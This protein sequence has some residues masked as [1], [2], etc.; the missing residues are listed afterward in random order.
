[1]VI[2]AKGYGSEQ[3]SYRHDTLDAARR[4]AYRL[5]VLHKEQ[6]VILEATELMMEPWANQLRPVQQTSCDAANGTDYGL[7]SARDTLSL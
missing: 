7:V 2:K 6:F 1:M 4:E 5:S 3:T